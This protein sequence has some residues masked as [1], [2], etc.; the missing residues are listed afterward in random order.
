VD[1]IGDY[2]YYIAIFAGLTVGSARATGWSGFW[3]LGAS[4]AAGLFLTFALLIVLRGRITAGRPEQL[5]A[6]A[7]A[8][9]YRSGKRW[10][11]LVAKL[12]NCATRANM[13]Y[14]ILVLAV[15]NLLPVVLVLAV[16]G[17]HVYWISLAVELRR[18]L[19]GSTRAMGSSVS[20]AETAR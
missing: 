19:A 1:T 13:P 12:S 7:K 17:A 9:F 16:I 10:K 5:N 3:W 15:L 4:V 14:G 2:T 11:W 8:H 18:L 20:M 6:N